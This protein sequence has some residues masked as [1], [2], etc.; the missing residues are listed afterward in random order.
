M[1]A[2]IKVVGII[3][4]LLLAETV[5][6]TEMHQDWTPPNWQKLAQGVITNVSNTGPFSQDSF[7]I[8]IN[9]QTIFFSVDTPLATD[10]TIARAFSLAMLYWS[11][12]EEVVI[13]GTGYRNALQINL[14][15]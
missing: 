13:Y 4:I 2:I 8:R 14:L 6:A 10:K 3:L 12:Q 9:N 11:M 7:Y 15:E 1:K 5:F